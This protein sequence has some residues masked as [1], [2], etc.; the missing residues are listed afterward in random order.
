MFDFLGVVVHTHA[1]T[2]ERRP[3]AAHGHE[4]ADD[5]GHGPSEASTGS[6]ARRWW[7]LAALCLAQF[8]VILDVTVVNVALPVMGRELGLGRAAST[9]VVTAYTLCFGGLMLLG[10]RMA[11]V[12]G[13]RN[14][15]VVG[16]VVFTAASLGSGLAD[17]PE[18][19]IT[20]RALQGVGAAMLS[21]AALSILTTTFHGPERNKALG[22]WAA[23]GG[24]GAAV[25]VLL[26]GVFTDGP[27]W[28]WAFFVNVPV[29]VALAVAVPV[30]VDG[31]SGR[32]GGR[33]DVPGALAATGAVG[34][35]IY[36]LVRAGDDGWG[37][38]LTLA[39]FGAGAA[40]AAL[41][42]VIERRAAEPLVRLPEQGRRAVLSGNAVMLA[43]SGL[44]LSFF[45]LASQ[46]MQRT[47][48]LD[49]LHTGLVFL[50]VAVAIGLG[51]HLGMHVVARHGGR[52]AAVT[53]FVLAGGGALWL[54][55]LPQGGSAWAHVLPGFVL[56]GVGLGA[57]FVAA[58]TTALAYVGPHDAGAA[59]G[60]VN[61][62]HEL[63]GTLGIAVM[64]SIAASSLDAVGAARMSAD[65]IGTA[66]TAAAVAAGVVAIGAAV[67]LPGGLPP[68]TD[69]PMFA[70]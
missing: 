51:S 66:F 63:G 16:L 25:G 9:W 7:V 42:V 62:G 19:L 69:R 15:F 28:E 23:L 31:G 34:A 56:A 24:A 22:V 2:G 70:H 67:L 47:L 55:R 53:G 60:L 26:G 27:G 20:A 52:P 30:L 1:S 33:I 4:Q 65:G 3:G 57:A 29:G 40:A 32:G 49:A 18:A 59:S 61:T 46:Y 17:G 21:P 8:M 68:E 35:L 38:G 58:T 5:H 39:A 64:S 37:D 48:G 43:A 6:A 41:F 44:L 13:R 50:P 54:S 45:F 36:A 11:D 10:G 14:V 12:Y